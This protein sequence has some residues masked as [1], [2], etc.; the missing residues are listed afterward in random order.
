MVAH[1]GIVAMASFSNLAHR[2]NHD[3]EPDQ[4]S[5]QRVEGWLEPDE[6]IH[7]LRIRDIPLAAFSCAE[8]VDP[9]EGSSFITAIT[10]SCFDDRT[11]DAP[12]SADRTVSLCNLL[13]N[14]EG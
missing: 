3:F 9:R 4:S 1:P 14:T 8:L 12:P 6:L 11:C 2:N 7:V 13:V 10:F 5:W